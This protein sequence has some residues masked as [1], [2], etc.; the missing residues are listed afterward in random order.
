MNLISSLV[1]SF[2]GHGNELNIPNVESLMR[3]SRQEPIVWQPTF[4]ILGGQ[5]EESFQEQQELFCT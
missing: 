4:Q 2:G 1:G 3:A 5:S